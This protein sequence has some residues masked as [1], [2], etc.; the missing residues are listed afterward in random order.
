MAAALPPAHAQQRSSNSAAPAAPVC[1]CWGVLGI[2]ISHHIEACS[3]PRACSS[4]AA[5]SVVCMD[6]AD[7]GAAGAGGAGSGRFL[8]GHHSL[9]CHY[10]LLLLPPGPERRMK[11]EGAASV[12]SGSMMMINRF[13]SSSFACRAVVRLL[14]DSAQ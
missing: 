5:K 8:I 1:C 14:P 4:P 11:G 6:D 13:C 2:A 12:N 10:L 3:S 7:G 9:R